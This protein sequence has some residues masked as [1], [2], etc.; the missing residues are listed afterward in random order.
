MKFPYI[1]TM[2]AIFILVLFSGCQLSNEITDVEKDQADKYHQEVI[3]LM[4]I[5]VDES[6]DIVKERKNKREEYLIETNNETDPEKLTQIDNNIWVSSF[7]ISVAEINHESWK[8]FY[9]N[10]QNYYR[11]FQQITN[12]AEFNDNTEKSLTNFLI[13][14]FIILLDATAITE[15]FE[16]GSEYSESGNTDS[17]DNPLFKER[18]TLAKL[19]TN[20]NYDFQ[21]ICNSISTEVL[22]YFY[23]EE[24][25]LDNNM[26]ETTKF[27]YFKADRDRLSTNCQ[28][29]YLNYYENN[30]D[31]F[32][33][34]QNYPNTVEKYYYAEW[35]LAFDDFHSK[36]R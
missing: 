26:M 24:G 10:E 20:H 35:V 22:D 16:R 13:F 6:G 18:I 23:S 11:E 31:N 8:S 1:V 27:M 34:L 25:F 19:M 32:M 15:A 33:N 7:L 29:M 9:E 28:D 12:R 5:I 21:G 14:S 17:F 2:P 4:G 30:L 3:E 36:Y